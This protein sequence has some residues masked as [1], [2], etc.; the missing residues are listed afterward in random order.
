MVSR[1][2]RLVLEID[3]RKIFISCGNILVHSERVENI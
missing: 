1:T 3:V 2:M